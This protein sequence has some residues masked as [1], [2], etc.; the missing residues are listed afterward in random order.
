MRAS[1]AVDPHS[2]ALTVTSDLLPQQMNGAPLDIRMVQIDIARE[3]FMFNPTNCDAMSIGSTVSSATGTA[4]SSAIPLQAVDCAILPFKPTFTVSTQGRASKA[5]GASLHV[6]VTSGQG[7]A[8]IAKVKVNLPLQLPSRLSTLQKACVDSV[9]EANPASCPAASAVGS[10]T[11]VTPLL[12]Q[13]LTGPAYLVSH[14]GAAFPDLEIVLQG[15]GI[16][17]ILDGN[18]QIKKGVTSSIFKTVPDAPISS[19][20][21]A[22]PSGPHSV[23]AANL[24][25]KAKFN[26]CG[27]K[28]N[29]PTVITGQ[30]GAVVRQTTKIVATGCPKRKQAKARHASKRGR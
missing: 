12:A 19:F 27:R 9:F 29:M 10:A 4:A 17:L 22:L 14:A 7:Q 20:D 16:K 30:N 28:L 5:G 15:E 6:K 25:A 1:V 13:P 2:G 21:L 8:N 26:L 18:T 23:L 24:P 11:A 3:G